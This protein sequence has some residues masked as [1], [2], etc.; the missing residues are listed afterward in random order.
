MKMKNK[1]LY[2]GN[3]ELNKYPRAAV[4]C[5]GLKKNGWGVELVTARNLFGWFRLI[6]RLFKRDYKVII[7]TGKP[8]L[9]I[10]LL[11]RPLHGKKILFD[12]FIS[13][14]ENLVL[15][16]K[17]IKENS[18]FSKLLFYLDKYS[19]VFSDKN[20]L[21]TKNHVTYFC[22]TFNLKE[23]IFSIIYVG[24]NEDI[25]FPL[26][27]K[28]NDKKIKVVFYG[29]FS[30]GHG[31]HIILKAAKL[32]EKY[33]DIEIDLI[34]RGQLSEEM[35]KLSRQLN[36]KNVNFLGWIDQKRIPEILSSSSIC[37]GLFDGSIE[38]INRVIPTKIF[39]MAAMKRPIITGETATLKEYFETKRNILFCKMS[40]ET[41]LAN[42]IS[43]L[44]K[45]K[46]LREKIALGGYKTFNEKFSAIKIGKELINVINDVLKA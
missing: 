4:L 1:V 21:D 31:I 3:F 43:S 18:L 23:D 45:N 40:S 27:E 19:C 28:I 34:G 5:D 25:F 16:R 20:I 10:N 32:L 26:K 8:T 29:S 38:K 46:T 6:A 33:K 9:W 41:S 13:D 2:V 30:P 17:R 12:V 37:L 24:A 22:K 7:A 39:E 15:N 35:T 42:A 14:Y 36:N 11:L 44:Y